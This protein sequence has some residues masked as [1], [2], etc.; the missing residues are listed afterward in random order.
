CRLLHRR[1]NGRAIL[2]HRSVNFEPYLPVQRDME[3]TLWSERRIFDGT[4]DCLNGEKFGI[5]IAKFFEIQRRRL[6]SALAMPVMGFY[7]LL[8]ANT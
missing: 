6:K 7:N 5:R 8:A 4:F 3:A 2:P 1:H